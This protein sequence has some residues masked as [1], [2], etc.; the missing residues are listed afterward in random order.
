MLVGATTRTAA[1][2]APPVGRDALITYVPGLVGTVND[3]EKEPP[4]DV[5]TVL[6]PPGPLTV[7]LTLPGKYDPYA[8]TVWPGPTAVLL[9]VTL[10][11]GLQAQAIAAGATTIT[12]T[13]IPAP[14]RLRRAPSA[15]PAFDLRS[16]GT[17]L[18]IGM[19][20]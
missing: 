1:D 19:C 8:V 7:M 11:C 20:T 16:T 9:S 2:A 14:T 18:W 10:A 5:V 17:P 6:E 13:R 15:D 12:A 3:L 4:V